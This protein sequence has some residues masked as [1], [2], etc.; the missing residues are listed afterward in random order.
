MK[1]VSTSCDEIASTVRLP[2]ERNADAQREGNG[3]RTDHR[4][5]RRELRLLVVL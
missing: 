2:Y 4:V 1:R 5:T 3:E